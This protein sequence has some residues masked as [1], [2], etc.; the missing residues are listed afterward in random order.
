DGDKHG[1]FSKLMVIELCGDDQSL[2][3]LAERSVK[4]ALEARLQLWTSTKLCL[5]AYEEVLSQKETQTSSSAPSLIFCCGSSCL[6]C[7]SGKNSLKV[8]GQF[9]W[10]FLYKVSKLGRACIEHREML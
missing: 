1:P 5:L 8:F 3:D 4:N 7:R 6:A 10:L 9:C 2:W